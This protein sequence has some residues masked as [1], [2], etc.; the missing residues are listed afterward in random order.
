MSEEC[1]FSILTANQWGRVFAARDERFFSNPMIISFVVLGIA[2][3]VYGVIIYAMVESGW[4]DHEDS[5]QG[6]GILALDIMSYAVLSTVPV[7]VL[8]YVT[9]MMRNSTNGF[10]YYMP[11][12]I[13]LKGPLL[14]SI[15]AGSLFLFFTLQIIKYGVMGEIPPFFWSLSCF[16]LTLILGFIISSFATTLKDGP[17]LPRR[18]YVAEFEKAK[19]CY[20]SG[21]LN[22]SP[23]TPKESDLAILSKLIAKSRESKTL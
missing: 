13:W 10:K 9:F 17:L 12:F 8:V 4:Y 23:G 22:T 20:E 14:G 2:M 19:Q 11:D 7:F 1:T 5:D 6:R 16:G 21:R 18:S 15:F 3:A